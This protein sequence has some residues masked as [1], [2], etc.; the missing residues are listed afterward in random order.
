MLFYYAKLLD[1]LKG[2]CQVLGV[3]NPVVDSDFGDNGI[4]HQERSLSGVFNTFLNHWC[5]KKD[6]NIFLSLHLG[7]ILFP[8][9]RKYWRLTHIKN[10]IFN[11]TTKLKCRKLWYFGQTAKLKC[12]EIQKKN[13]KQLKCHENFLP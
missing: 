8:E 12:Q 3:V 6:K 1:T 13:L 10:S 4:F 9:F 5:V 11:T 2:D 7:S